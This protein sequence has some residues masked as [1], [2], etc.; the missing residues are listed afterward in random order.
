[1][2]NIYWAIHFFFLDYR[3]YSG[4]E[5]Y[6]FNVFFSNQNPELIVVKWQENSEKKVL[7]IPAGG[8]VTYRKIYT[9]EEAPQPIRFEFYSDF[10]VDKFKVN[11]KDT[12]AVKPSQEND[13]VQV[14]LDEGILESFIHCCSF[15]VLLGLWFT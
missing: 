1:M 10:G 13:L 11:G 15:D 5:P 8:Y 14:I 12:I 9:E 4:L 7:R 2:N 6:F 3:D